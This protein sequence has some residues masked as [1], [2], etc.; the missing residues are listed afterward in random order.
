MIF[1]LKALVSEVIVCLLKFFILE[2]LESDIVSLIVIQVLVRLFL[3]RKRL[4]IGPSRD[5]KK[6]SEPLNLSF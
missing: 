1:R 2:V 4:L 5:I 3:P 6:R